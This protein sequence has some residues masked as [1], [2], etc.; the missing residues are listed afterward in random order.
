MYSARTLAEEVKRMGVQILHPAVNRSEIR[1]TVEREPS[2]RGSSP[3]RWVRTGLSRVKG[4]SHN[5]IETILAARSTGGTFQSLGDFLCR[6]PI[7]RREAEALILAGA[8]DDLPLPSGAKE[9]VNQSQLLWELEQAGS[10]SPR[11]KDGGGWMPLPGG[12][13]NYPPLKP[14]DS[15][16]RIQNELEILEIA[17]TDH[18]LRLLREEARKRGCLSTVKAAQEVGRRVRV[19]GIVAATRKV[20]TKKGEMMQFLTI[21]DEE[22]LLEST[23]FPAVYQAFGS[24]LRTLGPYVVEGRVEED[25]GAI[26]L[27]VSRVEAWDKNPLAG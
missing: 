17:I 9:P 19:A 24:R 2:A 25:H 4:L 10:S 11:E 20:R 18:P 16:T 5:S 21:E 26:N 14:Y 6:A 3:A 22:G 15:M 12:S 1:F 27:N 13:P 23:L 8:L 7:P